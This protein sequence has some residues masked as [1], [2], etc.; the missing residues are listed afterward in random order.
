LPISSFRLQFYL[1][2]SWSVALPIYNSSSSCYPCH[3]NSI[4]LFS[5]VVGCP[6]LIAAA[7]HM[8]ACGRSSAMEGEA[9]LHTSRC[10]LRPASLPP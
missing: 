8:R 2:L 6:C 10:Q 1:Y 3:M 5:I 9:A 4:R 7:S